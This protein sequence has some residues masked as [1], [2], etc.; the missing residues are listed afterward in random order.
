MSGPNPRMS[1]ESRPGKEAREKAGVVVSGLSNKDDHTA[2]ENSE[3]E[4]DLENNVIET[5]EEIKYLETM[6]VFDESSKTKAE[7]TEQ[8]ESP[9]TWH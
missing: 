9:E 6:K 7:P 8:L 3:V 2:P 5:V 1:G 4:T